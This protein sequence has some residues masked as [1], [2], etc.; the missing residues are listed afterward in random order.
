MWRAHKKPTGLAARGRGGD[1]PVMTG[2]SQ[3]AEVGGGGGQSELGRAVE[4]EG[5]EARH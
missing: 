2:I 1:R 4:Y 3:V 5:R